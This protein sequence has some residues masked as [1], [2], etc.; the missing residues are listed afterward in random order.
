MIIVKLKGGMGNQMFQYALGRAL[1][2]KYGVPL[3]L[4]LAFLLDRTPR[5]NFTFRNYDLDVFK[6]KADIVPQ[7][8]IPFIYRKFKSKIGLLIDFLRRKYFKLPG[9]EKKFNFDSSILN[10]GPNAYLDGYW[11]TEKYFN[12][13]EDVLRSEFS[14]KVDLSI[15]AINICEKI[16][17]CE[18]I[19]LHIRRGD[20]Y[21]NKNTN[22]ILGLCPLS[23]YK[24]AVN[25]IIQ[26]VKNP[27]FFIFSDDIDWC[28]NNLKIDNTLFF[29][30]GLKDYEDLILMSKCKHNIIA[31]SSFSWWGGWLNSNK[32]KIVIAP[33]KWYNSKNFNSEDLIPDYWIKI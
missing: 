15:E 16:K 13:I 2:I 9:V 20:Y 28:K 22:E 23:Y 21:S 6:I 30:G 24:D 25:L 17:S 12:N 11:Q 3:G 27:S 18:A 4:D 10:I 5:S 1:S 14:I 32:N 8:K 7:S 33:K 19:S 31:N 29:V 26:K